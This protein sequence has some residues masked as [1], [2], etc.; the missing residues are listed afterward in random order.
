LVKTA[1]TKH[2]LPAFNSIQDQ[3]IKANSSIKNYWSVF[4]FYPRSTF[5]SGFRLWSIKNFQFYPRSTFFS[6]LIQLSIEMLS[7]L[8]KINISSTLSQ[9]SWGWRLSILSKINNLN[10]SCR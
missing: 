1:I 8:S 2:T 4:Q 3:R 10:S 6:L 9:W 5:T 7:I